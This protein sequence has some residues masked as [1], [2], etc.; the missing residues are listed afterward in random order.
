MLKVFPFSFLILLEKQE[1]CNKRF[2]LLYFSTF[3]GQ[4][5]AQKKTR[6]VGDGCFKYFS[7]IVFGLIRVFFAIAHCQLAD[8][9][10]PHGVCLKV[11]YFYL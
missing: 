1:Y 11:T 4:K 6:G 8:W 9:A 5:F 7:I 10:L 3:F 2:A